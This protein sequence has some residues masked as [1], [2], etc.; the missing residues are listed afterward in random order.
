MTDD[1]LV[2]RIDRLVENLMRVDNSLERLQHWQRELRAKGEITLPV[3][4]DMW[5]HLNKHVQNQFKRQQ[6]DLKALRDEITG[7]PEGDG[8]A[9][10]TAR[11][12]AR[13]RRTNPWAAYSKLQR[14]SAQLFEECLE[15]IG[16]LAFRR[17]GLDDARMC[18]LADV[19]ILS[20]A[21]ES[22]A[23][24]WNFLTVPSL[25]DVVTK[26]R[27]RLSRIRFPEWTVWTLPFTAYPLG[28]EVIEEHDIAAL[29]RESVAKWQRKRHVH[30]LLAEIFGAYI[31][32][33]AYAH[34]GIQLRFDPASAYAKDAE[35][36]ATAS[37]VHVVLQALKTMEGAQ[38][39]NWA[40][41]VEALEHQ[42]TRARDEASRRRTMPDAT[43]M[44]D[45]LVEEALRHFEYTLN[46][47]AQYAPADWLQAQNLVLKWSEQAAMSEAPDAIST[48]PP[49]LTKPRDVL[50]AAWLLRVERPADV[51]RIET[52]ASGMLWRILGGKTA[53]P[54]AL[55]G[56][57]Q[58]SQSPIPAS[59]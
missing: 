45:E 52:A 42:W 27:A 16:G 17:T 7:A 58:K 12:G 36:P 34:A 10:P 51:P 54:G 59:P 23:E 15:F 29:F 18:E 39:A 47:P 9:G 32:G 21:R 26:S 43:E 24:S 30:V 53:G 57:G 40:G 3:A 4:D 33:P 14:D 5:G 28:H 2:S 11:P 1:L 50:N 13:R 19:L 22:Y 44:L 25:R 35:H 56:A 46:R 31:M 37:R 55:V 38:E 20:C 8:P 6:T 49:T 41:R 48:E